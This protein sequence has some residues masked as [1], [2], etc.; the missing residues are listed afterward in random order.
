MMQE[1][2]MAGDYEILQFIRLD[3]KQ[4]LLGYTPDFKKDI[5]RVVNWL[6]KGYAPLKALSVMRDFCALHGSQS[7]IQEAMTP[8]HGFRIETKQFQY[9]LRC[10]P[11]KGDY[12][13]Y[14]YCYAK[15]AREQE[16]TIPLKQP[17]QKKKKRPGPER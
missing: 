17:K 7:E 12:N 13:F 11:Q 5:D 6:R 1:K 10:A 3:G 14:L 9:M 15:A 4:L 8:S 16:H 2:E